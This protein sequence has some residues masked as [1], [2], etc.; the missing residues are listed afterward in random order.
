M[1]ADHYLPH[2]DADIAAMLGRCGAKTLDDLYSDVPA[3]LRLKGPYNLPEGLS[4]PEVARWF[5]AA[6]KENT[7]LACF[8]GAGFYNHYTPAA[9]PA[10]LAR[11]EFYTAY[12]P[13]QPEI[14]QGTLQ[15]I[16]EYQSMMCALTGLDVCNASM[17]DGATATA[18]AVMMAVN[19]AKKKRRVLVSAT[20]APAVATVVGTTPPAA[21][22]LSRPYRR[23]AA[24]PRAR[25][26]RR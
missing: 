19:A 14:S 24:S 15:Y 4:E 23:T 5:D 3:Q 16:F 9:I 10:M 7:T 25:H 20:L 18:E 22:S 13:Y 1:A 26:S 11:S 17:Y 12:T 6:G 2:T 8:A 21:E